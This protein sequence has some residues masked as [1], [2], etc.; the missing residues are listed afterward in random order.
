MKLQTSLQF[1]PTIY[2]VGTILSHYGLDLL[3]YTTAESGIENCTLFVTTAQGEFVLR[4]YRQQKKS[5]AEI[6]GEIAFSRFLHDHGIP[7]AEIVATTLRQMLCHI[8]DGR[9]DWQAVLMHRAS[10]LHSANYPSEHRVQLATTQARMHVAAGGY[11]SEAKVIRTINELQ[12]GEFAPMITDRHNLPPPLRSFVKRA[13]GYYLQLPAELPRGLC[14]LDYCNGNVLFNDGKISAVLDFD[15]LAYSPFVA[16]LAYSAWDVLKTEDTSAM[17]HYLNSYETV[18]PLDALE[19]IYL[20][21]IALARHYSIGNLI[22]ASGK[23]DDDTAA[24]LL[25]VERQLLDLTDAVSDG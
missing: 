4:I 1:K 22:I 16:C 12:D 10:G 3:E 15:D 2:N 5:D 23:T 13:E 25:S 6:A 11:T 19:T 17:R 9:Q 18:R 14:H 24:M 21:R 20:P 8:S 7:T